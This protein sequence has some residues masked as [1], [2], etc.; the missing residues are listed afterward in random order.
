MFPDNT[1]N[2]KVFDSNSIPH[3]L[4]KTQEKIELMSINLISYTKPYTVS[5]S[6]MRN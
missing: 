4:F 5:Y 6:G 2:R 1:K 3:S